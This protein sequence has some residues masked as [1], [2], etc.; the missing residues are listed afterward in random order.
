MVLPHPVSRNS[1]R[2][3]STRIGN[4]PNSQTIARSSD[5]GEPPSPSQTLV[6]KVNRKMNNT[7]SS[8]LMATG[9]LVQAHISATPTNRTHL[10]GT[11][12]R[13]PMSHTDH[14]I[15]TG[16]LV[17]AHSSA[18]PTNRTHIVGTLQRKPASRT[19]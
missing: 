9:I 3:P 4:I 19:D 5:H 17:R 7:V 1:R 14:L 12:R 6:R 13:R 18:T 2:N 16:I 15:V 11:L 10:A 8:R